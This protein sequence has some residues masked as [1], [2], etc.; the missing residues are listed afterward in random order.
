LLSSLDDGGRIAALQDDRMLRISRADSNHVASLR[1]EGKLLEPWLGELRR[2][3]ASV[4]GQLAV[5]LDIS[6]LS[7]ADPAGALLLATLENN[8]IR[9]NAASPFLRSLIAAAIAER[10]GAIRSRS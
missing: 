2:E 7:Y 3:I 6:G 8:G 9:L 10:A 4:D 5:E 1:L